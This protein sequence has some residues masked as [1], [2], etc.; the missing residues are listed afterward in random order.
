MVKLKD[1]TFIEIVKANLLINLQTQKDISFTLTDC[2]NL[3]KNINKK[4]F[5]MA[6]IEL[7]KENKVTITQEF[8]E[9]YANELSEINKLA[10]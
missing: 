1:E 2:E 5:F 6:L 4:H 3:L 7:E 8:K 9:H 10:Q